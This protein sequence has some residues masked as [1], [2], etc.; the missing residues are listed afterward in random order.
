MTDPPPSAPLSRAAHEVL[1]AFRERRATMAPCLDAVLALHAALVRSYNAGGKLLACGNGGSCADAIHI[2]GELGKSF[3]RKR[4]LPAPI[5]DRLAA[6]PFGEELGARLEAGLPAI[7]LG[8]NPALKT[9][10]E[11]DIRL[12]GIAFA[13]EVVAIGRPGDVLLAI[14]TSGNARNCV[15]AASAARALGLVTAALTGPDGG[16]LARN[17]DV[18]IRAPGESVKDIQEAH[19]GLY[20]LVCALIEAH[21]FPDPR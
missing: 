12:E 16:A 3:E 9:A 14:S 19:V 8:L 11:N 7:S 2:A 21:Y 10:T 5:L 4:P 17:V 1:D 15:M 18:A 20:H 13:Q 6:L